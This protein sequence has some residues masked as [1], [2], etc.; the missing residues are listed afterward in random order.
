[1]L[2]WNDLYSVERFQIAGQLAVGMS[3]KGAK[4]SK[5]YSGSRSCTLTRIQ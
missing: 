1:M 5:S 3:F 2:E 4:T